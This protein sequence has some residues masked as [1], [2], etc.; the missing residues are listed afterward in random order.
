MDKGHGRL[1]TRKIW[2]STDLNDYL[3]FPHCG[4]VACVERSRESFRT[5]KVHKEV[6]YLIT[7][8]SPQ[9]AAPEK[10]LSIS[11]GHWSIENKSHYVRDVT[12]DE[13]RSQVRTHSGPRV[14]ASLRNLAITLLRLRGFQNIA[15]A[16]RSLGAKPYRA[17]SLIGA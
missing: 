14:M 8:L 3:D 2:T 5:G 17:L 13:D 11:R 9:K 7:S 6:V 16:I 4:Q 1:E 15:Q 12:F 10:L